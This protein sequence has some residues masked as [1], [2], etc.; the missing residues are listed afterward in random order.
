M[1]PLSGPEAIQLAAGVATLLSG[2]AGPLDFARNAAGVDVLRVDGESVE[3]ASVTVGR[4]IGKGVFVG[5]RQGLG[6]QGSAVTVEIEVFDG[7]DALKALI[8]ET[9]S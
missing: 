8:L 5:A 6:G 1:T 4:N 3:D 9:V 7:A 2:N